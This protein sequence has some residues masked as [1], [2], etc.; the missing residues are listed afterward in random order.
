MP[1]C[2]VNVCLVSFPPVPVDRRGGS[3]RYE[4]RAQEGHG[5]L[6]FPATPTTSFKKINPNLYAEI[7]LSLYMYM[8]VNMYMFTAVHVC[9]LT[10]TLW[11]S[12]SFQI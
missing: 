9:S 11:L 3:R 8:F 1:R 12:H 10:R 5:E 7:I 4:G 6:C 2:A